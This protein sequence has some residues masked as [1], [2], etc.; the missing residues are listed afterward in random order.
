[1][2][3]PVSGEHSPESPLAA[4]DT[5]NKLRVL[6][7]S[8]PVDDIIG[9]H[10]HPG[11][12]LFDGNLEGFEVDL[13]QSPLGQAGIRFKTIGLLIVAGKVLGTGTD[14]A[15]LDAADE[16]YSHFSRKQRVL[17]VVFE[18]SAAERTAVDVHGRSEPDP[19]VVFLYF[20][21]PCDPDLLHKFLVPGTGQ[22]CCTGEGSGRDADTGLDTEAG[23][24]VRSHD[25]RNSILG[26]I[27]HSEG[28]GDTGVG[29]S[30][31]ETDL[32]L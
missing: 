20:H 16:G 15:G 9:G 8:C 7:S 21:A 13:A 3:P 19:N 5:G 31:E 30:A 11:S 4:E 14:P 6:G 17:R 2:V 32:V 23:R 27:S 18:I 29:L 28:I 26:E 1:M 22:E 10:D 24:S 25:R 12:S